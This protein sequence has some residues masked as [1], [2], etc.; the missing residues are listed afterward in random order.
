[1]HRQIANIVTSAG[2]VL[3]LVV[4]GLICSHHKNPVVMMALVVLIGLTDLTDG[5][6]AR[7]LKVVSKLGKSLDR[8]RDKILVVP[9]FFD[10]LISFFPYGNSALFS[11][12]LSTLLFIL[13]AEVALVF[14]WIYGLAFDLDISSHR[15]GKIK[16]FLYIFTISLWYLLKL[17]N[18]SHLAGI[19]VIDIL[20]AVSAFYALSSLNGYIERYTGKIPA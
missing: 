13:L 9:I 19:L 15:S 2:L 12:A 14:S 17:L 1:M 4:F 10:F 5:F 11:F 8:L 6:L 3:S 7:R 16:Q 20:L 18:I